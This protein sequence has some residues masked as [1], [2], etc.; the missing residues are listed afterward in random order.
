MGHS[1]THTQLIELAHEKH[2]NHANNMEILCEI[3]R[4]SF[5]DASRCPALINWIVIFN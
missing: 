5:D 3:Q 4:T 1:V 2:A